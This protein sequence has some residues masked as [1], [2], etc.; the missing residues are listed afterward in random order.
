VANTI[1]AFLERLTGAAGAYNEAKVG[2]LAFLG[3]VFLD[4][5]PEIARAGQTI[6]IYFP[7]TGA[8]SDQA[9]NDWIPTDTNP[10][11]VDIPFGLRPGYMVKVHDFEQFQT[12]TN[13]IDQFIDPMQKRGQ[14]YANGVIASLITT[15]NF[16]TYAALQSSTLGSIDIDTAAN[17]WDM[18]VGNKVPIADPDQAAL[19]T[20]NH[21]HRNMLTDT[22]WYQESLVGAMIA[23]G[24][25]V[26]AAGEGVS[27]TSFNFNRYWDQQVVTGSSA[28]ITG[29]VTTVTGSVDV[30]GAGTAFTTQAVKGSW[31]RFG[32][33]VDANGAPLFY[34]VAADPASATALKLTQQYQGTGAAGVSVKR[35]TYN[36][37]VMHRYAIALAVRP[38][39]TVDDGHIHAR[40]IE[41]NG[42]PF[43]V[44]V[45][46][47]HLMSS[48]ILS[49]DYGMVAK[50]IR[51]D[52]GIV[53]QS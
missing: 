16:P 53:I 45:S 22:Q 9:A 28:N 37:V 34:R 43:R 52:F 50:V 29:T 23:Q 36:S 27:R 25:R 14:E 24:T 39:E 32:T 46:W 49:M 31:L 7:D 41:L 48:W 30:T 11:F 5:R 19:I 35:Q 38:L 40:T 6:R 4:I 42:L 10:G 8:W 20:H 2:K 47:N 15:A 13:I 17:A 26:G 3:N 51:P 18:L 44:T 33:D 21:V 12:E 1:D